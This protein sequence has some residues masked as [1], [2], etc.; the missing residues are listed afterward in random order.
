MRDGGGVQGCSLQGMF[1]KTPPARSSI[2][3]AKPSSPA[4]VDRRA[5]AMHFPPIKFLK[6]SLYLLVTPTSVLYKALPL[7]SL[8]LLCHYGPP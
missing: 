3:S 1:L 6:I 7:F 5:L 2:A 8:R 4:S